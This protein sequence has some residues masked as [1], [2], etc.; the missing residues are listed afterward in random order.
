MCL[1]AEAR[2]RDFWSLRVFK[3]AATRFTEPI[4]SSTLQVIEVDVR[5]TET[6]D[7]SNPALQSGELPSLQRLQITLNFK[8]CPE[9]FQVMTPPI[10]ACFCLLQTN[11]CVKPNS[12]C[13]QSFGGPLR[14]G[15]SLQESPPLCICI[16]CFNTNCFIFIGNA[17]RFYHCLI[18][19]CSAEYSI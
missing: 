2:L 14:K 3:A 16:A 4:S 12:R 7:R 17:L 19:S 5:F 11:G 9:S 8:R 1:F 15:R 10:L 13:G 18:L 6:L